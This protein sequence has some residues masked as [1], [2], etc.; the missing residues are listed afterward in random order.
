[1]QDANSGNPALETSTESVSD[2][3]IHGADQ[4]GQRN[5]TMR[6]AVILTRRI[7]LV[8]FVLRLTDSVR[9]IFST[10]QIR[11]FNKG[12]RSRGTYLIA[13]MASASGRHG[14]STILATRLAPRPFRREIRVVDACALWDI[15]SCSALH[16]RKSNGVFTYMMFPPI[17]FFGS[18]P[19]NI[20]PSTCATTWFVRTH[21]TPNLR[22]NHV[23][24]AD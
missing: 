10:S 15:E 7:L 21:A 5:R 14:L 2:G 18:A 17:G 24:E 23:R 1:M 12:L 19:A 6:M 11:P 20:P 16:R 22:Y 9:T 8:S 13:K 4:Y 3:W